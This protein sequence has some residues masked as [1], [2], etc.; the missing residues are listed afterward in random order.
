VVQP[1]TPR[2]VL[3]PPTH[4]ECIRISLDGTRT[5]QG[6]A[7]VLLEHP[8]A[9]DLQG[10]DFCRFVILCLP[11]DPS[12]QTDMKLTVGISCRARWKEG[13]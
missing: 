12:S 2:P 1:K 4:S 3:S 13:I 7:V 9:D 8:V 5:I 11:F 10:F 6:T